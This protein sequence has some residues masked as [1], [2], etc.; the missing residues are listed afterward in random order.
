ML[1]SPSS[2]AGT[3]CVPRQALSGVPTLVARKPQSY[4]AHPHSSLLHWQF[5]SQFSRRQDNWIRSRTWVPK[6]KD[7][8]VKTPRRAACILVHSHGLS[9]F[10]SIS[11]Y[12]PFL[13]Y[14]S[15]DYEPVSQ[16]IFIKDVHIGL[17]SYDCLQQASRPSLPAAKR[18]FG[19]TTKCN[20]AIFEKAQYCSVVDGMMLSC[21]Q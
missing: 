3:I 1:S 19:R 9:H 13:P 17:F 15:S 14:L 18:T 10:S 7:A 21:L 20:V 11:I 5:A 4:Q 16:G 2:L 6:S 12:Q 8:V